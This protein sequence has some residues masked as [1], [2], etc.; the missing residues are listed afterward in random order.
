V[1]DLDRRLIDIGGSLKPSDPI[2]RIA[3]GGLKPEDKL[4]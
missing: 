4:D 3:G 2:E 1:F